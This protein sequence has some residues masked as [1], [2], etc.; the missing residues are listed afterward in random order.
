MPRGLC[1]LGNIGLY[2]HI[3]MSLLT[4]FSRTP[5]ASLTELGSY[6]SVHSLAVDLRLEHGKQKKK[7]RLPEAQAAGAS[8]KRVQGNNN[9]RKWEGKGEEVPGCRDGL[10]S[11]TFVPQQGQQAMTHPWARQGVII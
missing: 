3:S 11:G 9:P 2:R 7:P 1:H 10:W 8:K 4:R 5:P 6:F